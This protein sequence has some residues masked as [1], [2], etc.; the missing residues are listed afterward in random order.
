MLPFLLDFFFPRRSLHGDEGAYITDA[1]CAQIRL[2][3]VF[4]DTKTLH[5]RG[6]RHIDCI[7]AAGSYK[8]SPLLKTAIRRFKYSRF[9]Q[10]HVELGQRLADAL[11]Q[12]PTDPAPVLCPVPL[13]WTRMFQR[14]FNQAELLGRIVAEKKSWPLLRLLR[15]TRPTGHQAHR[16]RTDRLTALQNA[17]EYT[18]PKPFPDR[19]ILVDDLCTTGATLTACAVALRAAGVH[20]V[21][22]IVLA[23]G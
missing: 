5:A 23:E 11:G 7:V 15:R 21:D 18:G 9:S 4:L 16:G 20:S 17:F 12:L 2:T 1:E 10:L 13:H 19:V 14:G 6:I 22:A 3:P 8:S